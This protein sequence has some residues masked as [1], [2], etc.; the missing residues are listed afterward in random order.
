MKN[1]DYIEELI[2]KN[3]DLLNDNEPADGHFERFEAKL[4]AQGEPRKINRNLLLKI[5]AAV[6]FA[7]LAS[8]QLFMWLS[9]QTPTSYYNKH[10]QQELSLASLSPEY[11]EVEFYYTTSINTGL[12]QWNALNSEGYISS[13]EQEM[14]Q[15]ELKEFEDLYKN[16]QAD[17]AA[18]PNDER[19]INAMLEFYQTK[20]SLINMIVSKLEEVKQ[21]KEEHNESI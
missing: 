1:K 21:Q 17:L 9:P 8:N 4:K 7:F 19:V 11:Q 20:L 18:S 15:E 14:M 3:A 6:V 2:R 10:K 5:A 16:L 13:E 12:S